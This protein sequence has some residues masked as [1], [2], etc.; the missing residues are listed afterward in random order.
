[1]RPGELGV[2]QT[3]VSAV[4]ALMPRLFGRGT[5]L[6]PTR[7][8]GRPKRAETERADLERSRNASTRM[9]TRQAGV[10]APRVR[11]SEQE[12]RRSEQKS[13][14][15][16]QESRRGKQES[17]RG[18]QESRRGRQESWRGKQESWCEVTCCQI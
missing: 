2:A 4:S 12:S 5:E 6:A 1:M 3:L 7:F 11:R 9:S 17:R 8:P 14:C 13:R 15:G 16:K 18:K 10:P